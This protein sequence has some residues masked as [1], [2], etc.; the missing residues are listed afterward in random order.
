VVIERERATSLRSRRH[1][2]DS[3]GRGGH[4]PQFECRRPEHGRAAAV[5][6]VVSHPLRVLAAVAVAICGLTC[7]TSIYCICIVSAGVEQAATR[8]HVLRFVLVFEFGVWV[9][10]SIG[11]P[12]NHH[13]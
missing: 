1:Q 8:A 12:L 11:W 6:A 5:A 9:H 10:I 3:E 4:A 7:V 2:C 13:M